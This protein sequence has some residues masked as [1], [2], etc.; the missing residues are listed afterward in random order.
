MFQRTWTRFSREIK[1]S[2]LP[3]SFRQY[4]TFRSVGIVTHDSDPFHREQAAMA[5]G[6]APARSASSIC[7]RARLSMNPHLVEAT[8]HNFPMISG[9]P[10]KRLDKQDDT[11]YPC[12]Q[13]ERITR[14][15]LSG[16]L[17]QRGPAVA[18]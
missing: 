17:L 6:A 3:L 9:K 7:G 15:A 1:F 13:S 8:R 12:S 4:L 16:S 11:L 2:V 14:D 18:C 5:F 10:M